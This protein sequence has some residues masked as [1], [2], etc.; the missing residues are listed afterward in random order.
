MDRMAVGARDFTRDEN[1]NITFKVMT[2]P[3]RFIS[4]VLDP[5]DT[6]TVTYFK[7]KRGSWEKV[8]LKEYDTI[9][10]DMLGDTIYRMTL[11]N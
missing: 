8:I 7:I 2:K 1:G 6:Y 4:I 11:E 3:Y 9:Y 10:C 5:S